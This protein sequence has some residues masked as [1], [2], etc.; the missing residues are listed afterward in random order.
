MK[1]HALRLLQVCC[2]Y[3]MSASFNSVRGLWMAG[4]PKGPQHVADM[5]LSV[6]LV[7]RVGGEEVLGVEEKVLRL[8]EVDA[9]A[10]THADETWCEQ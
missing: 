5:L 1:K 4:R 10:T 7:V 6:H 9:E 2:V 3:K 8:V